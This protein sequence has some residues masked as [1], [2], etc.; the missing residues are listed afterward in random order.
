MNHFPV[1]REMPV[2]PPPPPVQRLGDEVKWLHVPYLKGI[3]GN[4]RADHLADVGRRRLPLLFGRISMPP[5]PPPVE[6]D[7]PDQCEEES[8]WGWEESE[9]SRPESVLQADMGE[10]T[11][12][13]TQP[14]TPAKSQPLSPTQLWDI[15][16]CTPVQV[17][18]RARVPTPES[19]IPWSIVRPS[20]M[21]STGKTPLTCRR[22][23]TPYQVG[24]AC[25]TFHT[26]QPLSPM[27]PQASVQLLTSLEL[28]AMEAEDPLSPRSPDFSVSSQETRS[29]ISTPDSPSTASK[30]SCSTAGSRCAT[31]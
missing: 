2:Y 9:I 16:F 26:P 31:P 14:S 27:S 15:E 25:T 20:R 7:E 22:A 1:I 30:V 21:G 11:P 3:K 28:V 8:I 23:T 19:A 10:D 24:P 12:P 29:A 6:D 17:T 4:G 18:K 13:A 5:P